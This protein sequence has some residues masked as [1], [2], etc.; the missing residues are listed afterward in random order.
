MATEEIL[1]AV[2]QF[3][4]LLSSNAS[5]IFVGNCCLRQGAW[6][7]LKGIYI[8]A[9]GHEFFVKL[10]ILFGMVYRRKQRSHASKATEAE[11][12]YNRT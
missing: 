4:F 7:L 8:P 11:E 9:L 1:S 10:H 3:P 2:I 12:E 6:K 5:S